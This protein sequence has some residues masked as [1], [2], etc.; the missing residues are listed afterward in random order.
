LP[1]CAA[2]GLNVQ[3]LVDLQYELCVHDNTDVILG[4]LYFAFKRWCRQQK[5]E[6]PPTHFN[7]QSIG[8]SSQKQYPVLEGNV[9][10]SHVKP[11][12][13][14]L[15]HVTCSLT[16]VCDLFPAKLMASCCWGVTNFMAAISVPRHRLPSD[17]AQHAHFAGL[18]CLQTY[19][20]LAQFNMNLPGGGRCNYKL[21]PKWHC[22]AHVVFNLALCNENPH[23]YKSLMEEDFMGK[24]TSLASMCH[25]KTVLDRTMQRYIVFLMMT[26]RG[27]I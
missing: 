9:K 7:L 5:L 19:Q 11:V 18:I 6:C 4:K 22:F 8:R 21:R 10:A 2:R 24:L 13:W 16:E 25:G 1:W 26:L 17:V 12:L 15:A 20:C 23:C 27:D 3:F 14:F